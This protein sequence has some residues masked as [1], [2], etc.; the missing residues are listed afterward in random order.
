MRRLFPF[1]ILAFLLHTVS[2]ATIYTW[3]DQ[4]GNTVYSDQPHPGASEIEVQAPQTYTPSALPLNSSDESPAR[5]KDKRAD[6]RYNELKIAKPLDDNAL[7]SNNGQVDVELTL[8]PAL[9]TAVGDYL[10]LYLDDEVVVPSTTSTHITLDNI[11]RG[12]HRLRAEIKGADNEVLRVSKPITFH[13]LRFSA[14]FKN[15][16]P[17]SPP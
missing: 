6:E 3:T 10:V 12:T 11:D 15:P 1:L 8:S 16:P 9:D 2:A 7:R 14:L 13:L 17:P 4:N 5:K